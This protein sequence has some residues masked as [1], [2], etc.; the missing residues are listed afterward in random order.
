MLT[1]L[2]WSVTSS[3]MGLDWFKVWIHICGVGLKSKQRLL[4]YT[5]GSDSTIAQEGISSLATGSSA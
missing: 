3:T 1:S 2:L 5:H 4:G